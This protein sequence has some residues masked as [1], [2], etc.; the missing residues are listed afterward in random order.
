[1]RGRATSERLRHRVIIQDMA[2]IDGLLTPV[3]V[4]RD[5]PALIEYGS[6]AGWGRDYFSS[7]KFNAEATVTITMRYRAG[8]GPTTRIVHGARTYDTIAPPA[9]DSRRRETVLLAQEVIS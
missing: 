4:A 5:V 3:E 8:L 7:D 9:Q 6:G 2:E 1:M